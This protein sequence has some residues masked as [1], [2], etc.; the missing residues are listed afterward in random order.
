MATILI[1]GDEAKLREI[2]C[3]ALSDE[4]TVL[5]AR[6]GQIGLRK[7]RL[8]HPDLVIISNLD[9]ADLPGCP[10]IQ[11]IRASN[12][13]V[14]IVAFT[15]VDDDFIAGYARRLGA[16]LCFSREDRFRE[17]K[18]AISELLRVHDEQ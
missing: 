18:K 8:N 13:Q 12:K 3:A 15:D 7:F 6:N 17:V 9:I 16:D 1:I 5:E 11:Q 10:L 4:H 2:L 14:K